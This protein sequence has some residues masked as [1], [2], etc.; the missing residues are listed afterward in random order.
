MLSACALIALGTQ[1]PSLAAV[2][3]NEA[4]RT[5]VMERCAAAVCSVMS[6]DSPAIVI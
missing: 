6:M 2:L 1:D 4:R 5:A 3:A